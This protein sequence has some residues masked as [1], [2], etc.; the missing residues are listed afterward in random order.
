MTEAQAIDCL[1]ALF[2]LVDAKQP[3]K[4]VN[5]LLARARQLPMPYEEALQHIVAGAHQRTHARLQLLNQ[6]NK[7]ST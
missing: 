6:C 3:E 1:L 2:N 5:S 7:P 4:G